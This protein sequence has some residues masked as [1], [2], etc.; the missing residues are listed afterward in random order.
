MIKSTTELIY[1]ARNGEKKAVIQIEIDGWI[2]NKDTV[3]YT[4]NDYAIGQNEAKQ[5]INSKEVTYTVSQVNEMDLLVSASENFTG[6]SKME[7]E[8]LKVKKALLL[9]TQQAPVYGSLANQWV[10]S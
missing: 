6:L 7:V 2:V 10:L 3:I 4:V 1:D 9:V 8:W 5:L